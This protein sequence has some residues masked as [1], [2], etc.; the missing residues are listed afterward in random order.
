MRLS[1]E[2]LESV[3]SSYMQLL[4]LFLGSESIN[5]K[6]VYCLLKWGVQLNINV[7]DIKSYERI[8]SD[9]EFDTNTD[10]AR[11]LFNLVFMIYLDDVV[12]D[13]EL[14][15]AIMYARELGIDSSLVGDFFK[16]IATAPFDGRSTAD[17]REE[18]QDYLR[19]YG[20]GE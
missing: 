3:K 11:A 9:R 6:Y 10:K 17:V 7:D 16:A 1:H 18:L 8:A 20:I 19:L 12:E 2:E 5:S 15:I 14:E 13:V 4:L